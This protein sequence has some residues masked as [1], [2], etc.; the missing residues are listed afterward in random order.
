MA[1]ESK[2]RKAIKE[3]KKGIE[4]KNTAVDSLIKERESMEG[5]LKILE[6]VEHKEVKK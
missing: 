3:L 6:K 5:T 1:K 2:L 4:T